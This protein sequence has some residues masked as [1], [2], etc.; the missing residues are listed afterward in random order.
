NSFVCPIVY[1][2]E[3]PP[4]AVDCKFLPCCKDIL[5][6]T[7]E[8][9]TFDEIES[10]YEHRFKGLNFL[11]DIDL[12]NQSSYENHL[13]KQRQQRLQMEPKD[14]ALLADI[15]PLHAG[16]AK[17]RPSRAQE[18]SLM[19]A[20]ERAQVPRPR[21]GLQRAQ[22]LEAKD[23][24]R[25]EPISLEQQREMVN[26]TFEQIKKPVLKHPT[27]PRSN[28][29]PVSVQPFFPDTELKNFSFVQMQFDIPPSDNSKSLIKDC[30][31][32]HLNFNVQKDVSSSGDQIYISDQR[33]KEEKTAE[34]SERGERF[35]LR[36]KDGK[37][38]YINVDKHIKLRRERPRPLTMANKC[39][40]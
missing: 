35:I 1:K 12:V 5:E 6:Y 31:N 14:A 18:C 20:K 19:F 15:E 9:V 39:L 36:E 32:Y 26:K 25:L 27:K 2:N 28:A 23:K 7:E 30:G 22:A 8:P 40:L 13:P 37:V 10:K 38:F 24:Q 11:F 16:S 4:L 34:N 3:I 21:T 29:H 33:Y 17:P